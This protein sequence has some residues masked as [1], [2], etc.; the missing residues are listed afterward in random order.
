[1]SHGAPSIIPKNIMMGQA[2]FFGFGSPGNRGALDAAAVAASS[3]AAAAYPA[4]RRRSSS[5]ILLKIYLNVL[6]TAR[7][8][9][10]ETICDLSLVKLS[11]T[12][13]T[14]RNEL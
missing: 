2:L 10:T 11:A 4:G 6:I 8:E 12:P 7:A 3:Q 5:R 1:M 9:N 13:K 14:A